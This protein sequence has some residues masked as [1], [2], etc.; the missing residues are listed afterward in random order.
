L[1]NWIFDLS[2][3]STG[4]FLKIM[5]RWF[6]KQQKIHSL[7]NLGKKGGTSRNQ[8][9]AAFLDRW[10]CMDHADPHK[11]PLTKNEQKIRSRILKQGLRFHEPVLAAIRLA[12]D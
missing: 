10:D 8:F 6:R 12:R 1:P 9:Q 5:T 4:E 2:K 7:S 11:T 3:V